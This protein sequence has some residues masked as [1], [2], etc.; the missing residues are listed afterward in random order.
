MK[1]SRLNRWEGY[2]NDLHLFFLK[3]TSHFCPE[4]PDLM[5]HFFS[6]HKYYVGPGSALSK[7]PN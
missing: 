1:L 5:K 4:Y 3:Y 6:S 7:K 2:C